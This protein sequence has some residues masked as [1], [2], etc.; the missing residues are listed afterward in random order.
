MVK[1]FQGDCHSVENDMNNWM[2]VYKPRIQEIKQ[3]VIHI[4]KEHCVMLIL[5][6]L[7]EAES[8]TRKVEYSLYKQKR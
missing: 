4:E 2:D 8:E 6:V 7:F 5:T 3:S 1:I